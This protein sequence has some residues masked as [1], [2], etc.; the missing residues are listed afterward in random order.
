VNISLDRGR[1]RF[2]TPT[3]FPEAAVIP[4]PPTI[5]LELR[6]GNR[7]LHVGTGVGY[8]TAIM[9]E[10]VGPEGHVTGIEVNPDLAPRARKNLEYLPY[11]EVM[12]RSGAE[13]TPE[14][15]DAILVNAGAT[16]PRSVW[17]D[18]LRPGGRLL[19]PLIYTSDPNEIGNGFM[20]LVKRE[21]GG[22]SARP[23][24]QV[25]IYPCLGVRDEDLN[26][27][28]RDL[29]MRGTWRMIRSVRREP[30]QPSTT[31]LAHKD[32]EVCLSSLPIEQAPSS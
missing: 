2:G 16:H 11:V 13:Y 28:L 25:S 32:G 4:L 24:S 29:I 20:L 22:Y 1:G 14:P 9:A 27:R 5:T 10:M 31:C 30:H 8:Y 18:N 6:E 15:V 7:I 12:N 23:I 26:Q 19:L 17:L 3:S 21:A